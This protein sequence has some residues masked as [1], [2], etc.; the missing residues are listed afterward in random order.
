MD[1]ITRPRRSRATPAPKHK[2]EYTTVL[3]DGTSAKLTQT[4]TQATLA[5][6]LTRPDVVLISVNR[7]PPVYYGRKKRR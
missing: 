1:K 5:G 6:L 4:M 2:V 3:D 7:D